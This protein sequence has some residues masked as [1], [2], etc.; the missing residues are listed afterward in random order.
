M[1][2]NTI[3]VLA[4]GGFVALAACSSSDSDKYPDANSFCAAKADAECTNIAPGC[5]ATLEACKTVRT[6]TCTSEGTTSGRAYTPSKAQNCIDQVNA[7]YSK[8]TFTA[9]DEKTVTNACERVFAGSVAQDAPCKIDFDCQGDMICDK[10]VCEN[11][12][13]KS[14]GAL[15]GNPGE[16]CDDSS[17]CNT[18]VQP[19]KCQPRAAQAAACSPTSPCDKTLRCVIAGTM[20]M[21]TCQALENPNDPCNVDSDCSASTTPPYCDPNQH[22]CLPKYGLGTKSCTDF[23]AH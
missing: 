11:K 5:N 3:L 16:V 20:M 14:A 18:G 22:K 13:D 9:D 6:D 1:I 4:C 17:F 8:K 21:G 23:G 19:V 12:V 10:G 15:C 7:V 2:R